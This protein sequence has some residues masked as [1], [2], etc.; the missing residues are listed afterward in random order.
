LVLQ[1]RHNEKWAPFRFRAGPGDGRWD[2]FRFKKVAIFE[3]R[4]EVCGV[5]E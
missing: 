3:A 2:A 4:P 1:V 5:G